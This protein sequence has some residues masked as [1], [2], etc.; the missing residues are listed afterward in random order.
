MRATPPL[1][2]LGVLGALALG[3]M[4]CGPCGGAHAPSTGARSV[5][6]APSPPAAPTPGPA[7]P[8]PRPALP[9]DRPGKP[10]SAAAALGVNEGVAIP[11][12]WVRQ[13]QVA[14]EAEAPLLQADTAALVGLGARLVRANTATYPWLSWSAAQAD[15]QTER[16]ADAWVQAMQAAGLEPLVMLGPWP[17]NQTAAYTDAYV[18]Q[19]LPAY[20]AWVAGVVER[21]DG[22]GLDDMPG[23]RGPVR[24]W[25]VDNEPDL[26]NSVAPRDGG[27]KVPP[28]DFQTPAQYA[29]VLIATAQAIRG[30]DPAAVVLSAGL[31]RSQRPQGRQWLEQLL[32]QPGAVE[33]F[34][35]LSLHLYFHEDSLEPVAQALATWR[36]T[37]PDKPLWV[38]ETGVPSVDRAPHIGPDWQGRMVAGV[39]GALLAGGADRI[40]W[41]TLADPPQRTGPR[42]R[43]PFASHSLLRSDGAGGPP[44]DKPAGAVYRRLAACLEG[45]D[46]DTLAEVP[47]D[48]G[49]LLSTGTGWLAFWGS[50]TA[51]PDAGPVTDLR[52]GAVHPPGATID[53][54]AC[55][56]RTT[57]PSPIPLLPPAL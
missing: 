12:A 54:P 52:T 20:Q 24:Y 4:A 45:V 6:P 22:D 28:E 21:Y 33:A 32:A 26:H 1:A 16:R 53:A 49:R 13:G 14:P 27:G 9:P 34:D 19:D 48:G 44:Q 25:E 41:H 18:P 11:Q 55:V 10:A 5:G 43:S 51:P 8:P 37:T 31:Y 35:V 23:L 46:I 29:T 17:G 42:D 50:P 36:A 38:T 2:R 7:A 57:P 15:P 39:Y 40:L 30:A 47:A 3:P 56:A